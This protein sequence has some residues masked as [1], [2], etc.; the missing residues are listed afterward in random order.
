MAGGN[1]AIASPVTGV[2]SNLMSPSGWPQGVT[3][4]L[5]PESQQARTCSESEWG[6]KGGLTG[7]RARGIIT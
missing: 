6:L 7:T 1:T 3:V 4:A 5:C 2:F